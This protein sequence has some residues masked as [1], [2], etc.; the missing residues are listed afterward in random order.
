MRDGLEWERR[1]RPPP[2]DCEG[3]V[4]RVCVRT[5]QSSKNVLGEYD[6]SRS[7][8]AIC[9]ASAQLPSL[10]AS[11]MEAGSARAGSP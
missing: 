6:G 8:A 9:I 7:A 3:T 2:R 5:L 1:R 11:T 10:G 4:R